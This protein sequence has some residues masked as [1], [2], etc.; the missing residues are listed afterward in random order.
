MTQEPAI[1]D[2]IAEIPASLHP[3]ET[4]RAL[5][6]LVE[7]ILA[8]YRETPELPVA[9]VGDPLECRSHLRSRYDFEAA[10]PLDE[11]VADVKELMRRWTTHVTHPRN[12]GNFNPSVTLPS[13]IG[14]ALTALYNPQLAVWSS[15]PAAVEIEQLVLDVF[16]ARFGLDT[17]TSIANFTTGGAEANH[18]A[19]IAALTRRF[20]EYAER[21][22]GSLG[23]QPTIYLSVGGHESFIKAAHAAGIGRQAVRRVPCDAMHRMDVSALESMLDDDARR[24]FVPCLVIGTAGSTAMGV[25]DP[26]PEIADVCTRRGLWLHVDAAWGGAAI[27]SHKLK[28]ALAGIERADSITCDAH[29]WLSMPMGAGMFFCRHRDA[30]LQ[31]FHIETEYMPGGTDH[32]PDPYTATMQ[33]S[34]RF[35]GLKLFMSLATNGLSGT[36]QLIE[37][38]A[39]MGDYLRGRLTTL[40]WNVINDTPFPVVC[41]SH[42]R[43]ADSPAELTRVADAIIRTGKAWIARIVTTDGRPVLKA[44]ITS[45]RT[46]T[47]DVDQL[48][49]LLTELIE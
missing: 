46:T 28:P 2:S 21:G 34:R 13:V 33:W 38:Q 12:F 37:R 36:T 32:M 5:Q 48:I 15:A 17:R 14:D 27:L 39:D 1:E 22:L 35:I 26:L 42:E 9:P 11:L 16:T 19:L 8:F 20:P 24:R 10:V 41:F 7:E 47:T 44:C 30:V 31:S 43:L 23:L 25:I 45:Y 29:K 18:S 4:E 6:M 3:P 49:Q 40:G